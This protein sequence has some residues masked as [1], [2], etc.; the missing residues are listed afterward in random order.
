MSAKLSKYVQANGYLV[1]IQ[2]ARIFTEREF[3][4]SADI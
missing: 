4:I 1:S 3:S 2:Y